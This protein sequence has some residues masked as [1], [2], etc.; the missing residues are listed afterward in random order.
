M[1]DN[2]VAVGNSD[3]VDSDGDGVGD[4]CDSDDDNDGESCHLTVVH[5]TED[6][7]A[8]RCNCSRTLECRDCSKVMIMMGVPQ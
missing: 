4:A 5:V 6:I 7:F 3:Q 8:L 2:C 1:C